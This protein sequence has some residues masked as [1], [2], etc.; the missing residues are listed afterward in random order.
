M[1]TLFICLFCALLSTNALSS[2]FTVMP[3]NHLDLSSG[4]QFMKTSQLKERTLQDIAYT[5]TCHT[6]PNDSDSK[7]PVNSSIFEDLVIISFSRIFARDFDEMRSL[8]LQADFLDFLTALF[9][10]EACYLGPRHYFLKYTDVLKQQHSLHKKRLTLESIPEVNEEI[11]EEK[12]VNAWSLMR[13]NKIKKWIPWLEKLT[14]TSV[15]MRNFYKIS[16]GEYLFRTK[17]VLEVA[18]QIPQRMIY[19]QNLD[20][21]FLSDK[22]ARTFYAYRQIL[23]KALTNAKYFLK[24][25]LQSLSN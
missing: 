23:M 6:D 1:R 16:K 9:V 10:S 20:F 12:M 3:S 2:T 15:D 17:K 5:L 11:T 25:L 21:V 18:Y 13:I 8:L 19:D 22:Y 4:S 7:T 14:G 24:N